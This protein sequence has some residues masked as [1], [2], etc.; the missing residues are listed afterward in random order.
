M[1]QSIR[2]VSTRFD[3]SPR[4]HHDAELLEAV[5]DVLI[6]R[7]FRGTPI[8]SAERGVFAFE[9]DAIELYFT[10]RW[11]NVWHFLDGRAHDNAWY[12]NVSRPPVFDG[13]P[14]HWTDLYLDVRCHLDGRLEVLDVDEFESASRVLGMPEGV[15]ASAQKALDEILLLAGRGAFPFDHEVQMRGLM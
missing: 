1:P 10:R 6:F 7:T 11:Y 9:D 5:D 15:A 3:G 2:I 4:D 12:A 14:L 8:H 13:Q